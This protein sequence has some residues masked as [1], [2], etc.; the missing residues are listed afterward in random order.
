MGRK[1]IRPIKGQC[2][3]GRPHYWIIDSRNHGV[4]KYCQEERDFVAGSGSAYMKAASRKG[5]EAYR[6]KVLNNSKGGGR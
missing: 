3:D 2:P 6:L 4:C 5:G 1:R